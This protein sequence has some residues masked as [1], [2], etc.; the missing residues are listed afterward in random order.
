MPQTRHTLRVGANTQRPQTQCGVT[1]HRSPMNIVFGLAANFAH[2]G[3][4]L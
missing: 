4:T 2:C 3:S 1:L